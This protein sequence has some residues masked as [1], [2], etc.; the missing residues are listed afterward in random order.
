MRDQT[1]GGNPAR[2]ER[3]AER[4]GAREDSERELSSNGRILGRF[5]IMISGA[6]SKYLQIYI[7]NTI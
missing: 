7:H 2:S 3:E 4:E 1:K 5:S 6:F